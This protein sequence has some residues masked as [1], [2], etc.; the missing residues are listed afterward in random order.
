MKKV[1]MF[2]G[3]SFK[4]LELVGQIILCVQILKRQKQLIS[5]KRE[6]I[7]RIE[8]TDEFFVRYVLEEG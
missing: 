7:D 2:F 4:F 8:E 5:I 1:V 6:L 3:T